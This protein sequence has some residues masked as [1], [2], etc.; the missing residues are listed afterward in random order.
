MP[1]QQDS[2]AAGPGRRR[3][4]LSEW[5]GR[6]SV[7][8]IVPMVLAG[9]AVL[10]DP[11]IAGPAHAAGDRAVLADRH[12]GSG[13]K[14]VACHGEARPKTAAAGE[15]CLKCHDGFAKV[16]AAT[17]GLT[18]NPHQNHHIAA[19]EPDCT[20]CHQGHRADRNTCQ[21]CHTGMIFTKER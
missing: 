7:S 15:G 6:V 5:P 3:T 19:T 21:D 9:L 4:R 16:A 14:C 11:M 17:R 10:A 1:L 8:V 13:V 20:D 2:A 18:P 12:A